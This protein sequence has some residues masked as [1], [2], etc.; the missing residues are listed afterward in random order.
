MNLTLDLSKELTQ[1]QQDQLRGLMRAEQKTMNAVITLAIKQ[2][3]TYRLELKKVK[4][5]DNGQT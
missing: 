5:D 3:L 2:Y 4:K 1:Q